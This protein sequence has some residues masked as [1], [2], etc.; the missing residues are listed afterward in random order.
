MPCNRPEVH[1]APIAALFHAGHCRTRDMD[2]SIDVRTAHCFHAGGIESC[3][4]GTVHDSGIVHQ[5]GNRSQFSLNHPHHLSDLGGVSEGT[6]DLDL[7]TL[8]GG[9][10]LPLRGFPSGVRSGTRAWSAGLEWRMPLFLVERGINAL[11]LFLERTWAVAFVDAGDAWATRSQ[12][13]RQ[14]G[15]NGGPCLDGYTLDPLA[16]AGAELAL[17]GAII[18]WLEIALRLGVARQLAGGSA[19]VIYLALGSGGIG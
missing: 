19:T 2:K 3:E 4:C 15:C 12:G 8:G 18:H 17:R 6:L 16:S 14:T 11:P 1:D 7:I 9:R 13:G 5:Y 10:L